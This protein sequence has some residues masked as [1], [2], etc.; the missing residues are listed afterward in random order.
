MNECSE[1]YKHKHILSHKYYLGIPFFPRLFLT[2]PTVGVRAVMRCDAMRENARFLV[3]V[4][5]AV[6]FVS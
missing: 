4:V 3:V 1:E 2:I 5:S 6:G